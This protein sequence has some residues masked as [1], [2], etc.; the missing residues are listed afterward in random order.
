MD[1]SQDPR[2][3]YPRNVP[4]RLR[5]STTFQLEQNQRLHD[6]EP[7][8]QQPQEATSLSQ[9]RTHLQ[10]HQKPK[11]HDISTSP[12]FTVLSWNLL[13][14]SHIDPTMYP[15]CPAWAL[16]ASHRRPLLLQRLFSFL[17]PPSSTNTPNASPATVVLPDVMCFQEVDGEL[18]Q[19]LSSTLAPHGFAGDWK[20]RTKPE[21]M[22]GCATF[23]NRTRFALREVAS[24]E[25]DKSVNAGW[26]WLD[27]D[28]VALFHVLEDLRTSPSSGADRLLFISNTHLL[29]N[30]K[31][32]DLKLAQ[33]KILTDV[34]D[35]ICKRYSPLPVSVLM[36]GDW[37]LTPTS[38]LY[39]LLL[40]GQLPI[41]RT[42]FDVFLASGQL[43]ARDTPHATRNNDR[44]HNKYNH[45]RQPS[46]SPKVVNSG[47]VANSVDLM[48][49]R[50]MPFIGELDRATPVIR[51]HLT[52]RTAYS[53][54]TEH[55]VSTVHA[56]FC[57]LVDHIF[58]DP[59][60][61]RR[62]R[63]LTTLPTR[64][65]RLAPLPSRQ[66]PASDHLPLLVEFQW[67]Q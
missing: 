53:E 39:R 7:M 2:F 31:R 28:Q 45:H 1:Q 15:H 51:H 55:L 42:T 48:L 40:D 13:D 41:D 21:T 50:L 19:L 62:S 37:N 14:P 63:V 26:E 67:T 36:A 4:P 61:L 10:H 59:H 24:I 33:I 46:Y 12:T 23:Y 32:G 47:A 18:F 8:T 56:D 54:N 58:F 27:R 25:F 64:H 44:Y 49:Q 6:E 20:K 35:T 57:G 22:D 38:T 29:F 66:Q 11:T 30:P 65:A 9:R 43:D 3:K 16:E 52:L 34:T 5:K 60:H 17:A